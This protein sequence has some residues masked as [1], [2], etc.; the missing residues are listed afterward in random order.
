LH[1][2]IQGE[3]IG[4]WGD[5]L[6]AGDVPGPLGP[7]DP[8]PVADPTPPPKLRA[9]T[10]DWKAFARADV[11]FADFAPG[12]QVVDLGCGEGNQ[13]A[14]LEAAR[15]VST[16]FDV[17]VVVLGRARGRGLRVVAGAAEAMPLRT[18]AVDGVVC[19]VMLPYTDEARVVAEIGRILQQRGKAILCSHGAGY[20][21]RYLVE[22]PSWPRRA[23]AVRALLNTWLYSLTGWRL[24]GFLGDTLYQSRLRLA[25]Y[26]KG[27]QLVLRHDYP[28]RRFLG[29]PVFIY[30]VVMKQ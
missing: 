24:P 15:C 9:P 20:Y 7:V 11:P 28:A 8:A 27:A 18:A 17:D 22:G 29:L 19:K 14:A 25:R 4:S 26:Y 30:Q 13:L 1:Y 12:S 6:R 21:V 2:L 10:D 16:G 3:H 23:Y 5:H